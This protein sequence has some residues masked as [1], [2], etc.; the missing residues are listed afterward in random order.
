MKQKAPVQKDPPYR[1]KA[2]RDSAKGQPCM[3]LEHEDLMGGPY[4][5]E[6]ATVVWAHSNLAE[7]G[8]GKSL[9]A[10]DAFGLFACARCH[11]E[12]DRGTR[13]TN[14]QRRLLTAVGMRRTRRHLIDCGLVL[15]ADA[16]DVVFDAAWLEGLR[17]GRIRVLTKPLTVA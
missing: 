9:K 15:G 17:S 7:H 5:H 3:L 6:S 10:H 8:K 13:L 12:L 2:L 16:N 1:N 11:H 14:E 4:R